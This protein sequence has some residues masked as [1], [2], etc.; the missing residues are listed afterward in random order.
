MLKS[1][2]DKEVHT[3]IRGSEENEI[4]G[5]EMTFL[6]HLEELRWRLVKAVLGLLVATI[7]CGIFSDW[8]VNEAILRPSR[9]TKPP[10]VLINT[11]PY[12]QITFYMIVILVAGLILSSPWILYQL[13]KFIQPGL[14]PKERKYIS[15]IVTFTTICFLAGVAFAYFIMLPYMLQFFATFG[16]TSIQNMISVSEYVGFVLQLILISGLIFELPM[17]SYF[18]SR[19]GILTPKFMRHYRRHA[20]VVILI[21]AAVVTP[22][23]DPFTMGVFALPMMLLYEISIWIAGVAKR[24]RTASEFAG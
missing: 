10:L 9:L 4:A 22:T 2:I 13:W 1:A 16:T 23:T 21:I 6:D 11:I 19:L 5:K 14:M 12:G 20:I 17:V 7:L 18:L 24:R 8:F 3:P 15:G